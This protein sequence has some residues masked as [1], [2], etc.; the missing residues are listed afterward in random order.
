MLE[1]GNNFSVGERQL[2]CL[3]RA[4]LRPAAILILDE[5]TA[6]V[7]AATDAL[8]QKVIREQFSA[9]TVITIAH[10]LDTVMDSD[11]IVVL[12]N[13]SVLE[14]APPEKLLADASSSF[15]SLFAASQQ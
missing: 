4:V 3:A 14:H 12:D 13:G 6:N 1:F 8:I 2:I 5:A 9:C 11:M 15:A 10:R 7:D